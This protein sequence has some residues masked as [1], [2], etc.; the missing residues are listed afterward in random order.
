MVY[1]N[2]VSN[3][4]DSIDIVSE[5]MEDTSQGTFHLISNELSNGLDNLSLNI[6]SEQKQELSNALKAFKETKTYY[7]LREDLK[8]SLLDLESQLS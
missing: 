6:T 5:V 7:Y 1:I 2:N 8:N 3:F 4:K